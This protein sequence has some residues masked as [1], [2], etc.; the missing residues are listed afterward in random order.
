M[1]HN[2]VL[3]SSKINKI[4]MLTINLTK[5][6]STQPDLNSGALSLSGRAHIFAWSSII[7]FPFKSG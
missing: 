7:T 4:K 3:L 6:F 2:L 1:K 5:M